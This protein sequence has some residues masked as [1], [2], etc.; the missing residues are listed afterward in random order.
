MLEL[1]Q[2]VEPWQTT[3]RISSNE[4]AKISGSVVGGK[5]SDAR[6]RGGVCDATFRRR[7]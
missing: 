7:V 5:T 2:L 3:S 1:M 6:K 4:G